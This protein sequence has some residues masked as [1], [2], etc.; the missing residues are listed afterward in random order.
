M[1]QGGNS[2]TLLGRGII[3][4]I[5][6]L[7]C[8]MDSQGQAESIHNEIRFSNR[9]FQM[10]QANST[11]T[12]D[13]LTEKHVQNTH[14][15]SVE[16]QVLA[17]ECFLGG[18]E[19]FPG[20]ATTTSREFCSCALRPDWSGQTQV[21]TMSGYPNFPYH[22]TSWNRLECR[23]LQGSHLTLEGL[24]FF[25][26]EWHQKEGLPQLLGAGSSQQYVL[27]ASSKVEEQGYLDAISES[28]L[29]RENVILKTNS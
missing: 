23:L 28:K 29:Q 27:N 11:H 24:H 17:R 8:A 15:V 18:G 4:E 21:T 6:S 5:R 14:H 10:C 20:S 2:E 16:F 25:Y 1:G 22:Y 13:F 19:D 9:K 26:G 7:P 12:T 3:N